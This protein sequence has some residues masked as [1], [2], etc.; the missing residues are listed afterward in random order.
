[1]EGNELTKRYFGFEFELAC[2]AE[3][4]DAGEELWDVAKFLNANEEG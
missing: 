4:A 3:L 2:G 1:L